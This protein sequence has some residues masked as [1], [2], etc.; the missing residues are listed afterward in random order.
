[1]TNKQRRAQRRM[2]AKE[3]RRRDVRRAV[4]VNMQSVR[5]GQHA[6]AREEMPRFEVDLN[7]TWYVVRTLPRWAARAAE[8]IRSIGVPVFEAREAVRLV[9]DIGKV[10]VA[11]VPVLNRLL[12]VGIEDGS[13][14]LKWV[15]EHP[16][17]Y[18][19]HT[20]YRCGGVMRA[21]SGVPMTIPAIEMQNFADAITGYGGDVVRARKILFVIGQSV[22]VEDGPFAS[23]HGTVEEVDAERERLKVAVDIFGRATPVELDFKQ[24]RAA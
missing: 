6:D 5:S 12:F 7:R 14:E 19:D 22:V 17:V 23:F 24:V 8:Q 4:A 3:K 18:D 2:K 11:L 21:P 13:G 1:M 20:T 10:R 15:E 16:G 9:S